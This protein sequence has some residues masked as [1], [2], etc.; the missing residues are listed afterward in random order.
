[1]FL[2][3]L[4]GVLKYTGKSYNDCL[5]ALHDFCPFSWDFAFKWGGWTIE[6]K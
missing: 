1:M 5:K 2:L 3:K 6:E 4:D